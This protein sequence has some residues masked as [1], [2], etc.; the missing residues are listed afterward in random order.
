MDKTFTRKKDYQNWK[1]A[2]RSLKLEPSVTDIKW[3]W[4]LLSLTFSMSK[5]GL[6]QGGRWHKCS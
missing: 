1:V 2:E 4:N 5:L 3:F 6:G